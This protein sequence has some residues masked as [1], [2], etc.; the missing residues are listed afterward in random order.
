MIL[1]HWVIKIVY[2]ACPILALLVALSRTGNRRLNS[3]IRFFAAMSVGAALATAVIVVQQRQT[4]G[5][6]SLGQFALTVYLAGATILVLKGFDAALQWAGRRCFD[7]ESKRVQKL[8][9]LAHLGRGV[10]LVLLGLPYIMSVVFVY[11]PKLHSEA[12]PMSEFQ[13]SYEPV[14]FTSMDG[15]RLSGWWIPADWGTHRGPKPA[16]FG[17]RTVIIC[18]GWGGNKS[19][20]LVIARQLVP[21]GYNALTF[22]FRG[23]GDSAGQLTT[24]GDLERRDVL[25]AVRWLR[26]KYP[27]ESQKIVGV[28]A[29]TGAAALIAAAAEDSPEGQAIDAIAVYGAFDDLTSVIDEISHHSLLPPMDRVA[30]RLA[31]SLA[32]LHTGTNLSD[33]KPAAFVQNL[34]PRP[35]LI[36]H[37]TFDDLINFEHGDR[38]FKAATFPK[39]NLW[40][41]QQN[42]NEAQTSDNAAQTVREFFDTAKAVPAI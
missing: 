16:R 15:V 4:E 33:F 21:E 34:W 17:T 32:S 6:A 37:G 27:R 24:L 9:P 5:R 28:G 41:L 42:E 2:I 12:T 25:G 14:T 29:S 23:H 20:Q 31:M 26:L 8:A 1:L 18:H 35:I 36:I 39:Q 10:L 30:S 7:A 13:L 19:T 22:D 38:L 11:R 40:L 3:L